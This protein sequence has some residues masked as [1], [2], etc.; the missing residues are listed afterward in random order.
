MDGKLVEKR[1]G[2]KYAEWMTGEEVV[3]EILQQ[4]EIPFDS[5]NIDN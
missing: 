1:Y 4:V 5:R 3:I 2:F